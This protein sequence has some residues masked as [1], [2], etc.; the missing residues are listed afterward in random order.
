[1]VPHGHASRKRVNSNHLL[2]FI[3]DY[4][5]KWAHGLECHSR[6]SRKGNFS[7]IKLRGV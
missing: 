7:L 3:N 6:D 1:M 4:K 2:M 5:E